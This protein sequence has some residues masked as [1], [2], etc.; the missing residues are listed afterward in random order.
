MKRFNIWLETE[1]FPLARLCECVTEEIGGGKLKGS[2]LF[3]EFIADAE[4]F[5]SAARKGNIFK[6]SFFDCFTENFPKHLL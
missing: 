4:S 5:Y 2:T 1:A 3:T 6:E